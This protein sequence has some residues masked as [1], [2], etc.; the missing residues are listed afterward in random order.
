MRAHAHAHTRAHPTHTHT[1]ARLALHAAG[2]REEPAV[3]C[4]RDD[5]G[6]PYRPLG[7][8]PPLLAFGAD[9]ASLLLDA[10]HRGAS[11]AARRRRP[12]KL[13]APVLLDVQHHELALLCA[14]PRS[15]GIQGAGGVRTSGSGG[16]S[17]RSSRWRAAAVNQL[18]APP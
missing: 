1:W 11:A 15:V 12:C 14:M 3:R 18:C 8:Q 7:L 6:F 5:D 4:A 9:A 16:S 2:H 13:R 10:T 17:R